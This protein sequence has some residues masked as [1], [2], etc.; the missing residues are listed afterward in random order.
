[1]A[2]NKDAQLLVRIN[3]DQKD[4]FIALC[5][6]LETSSSKEIRK[7]IKRF[8]NKHKSKSIGDHNG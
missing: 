2:K 3:K 8:L 1:M 5:N 7:F 4:Q 6:E